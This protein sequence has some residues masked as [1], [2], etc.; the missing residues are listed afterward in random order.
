MNL[1]L[2]R[3]AEY[4]VCATPNLAR[5]KTNAS[6]AVLQVEFKD[7]SIL[8]DDPENILASSTG[9]SSSVGGPVAYEKCRLR[10]RYLKLVINIIGSSE[11][12]HC[13][14]P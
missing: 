1:L 14:R 6:S 9:K 11:N 13:P 10:L 7:S 2:F 8:A 5:R 3:L 12:R 4:G